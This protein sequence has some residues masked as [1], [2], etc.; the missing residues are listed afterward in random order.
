MARLLHCLSSGSKSDLN[1]RGAF[2]HMAADV[3]VLAW[4]GSPRLTQDR[5][6]LAGLSPAWR[7]CW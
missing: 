2:L 4:R 3:L 6:G 1:I 7:S 5:M